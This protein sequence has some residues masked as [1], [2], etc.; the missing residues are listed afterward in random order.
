MKKKVVFYSN[1]SIAYFLLNDLSDSLRLADAIVGI[2]SEL[3]KNPKTAL[4]VDQPAEVFSNLAVF[5]LMKGGDHIPTSANF[6]VR[7]EKAIK[8]QK[9][10]AHRSL[11]PVLNNFAIFH[12]SQ[13]N[14]QETKKAMEELSSAIKREKTKKPL[15]LLNLAALLHKQGD[16]EGALKIITGLKALADSEEGTLYF[17][18]E[19]LKR[20][21]LLSSLCHAKIKKLLEFEKDMKGYR[22][23]LAPAD[24]DPLSHAKADRMFAI[25]LLKL[26]CVDRAKKILE[27]Y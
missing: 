7:A 15:Y 4:I 10:T 5:Y 11:L 9:H 20:L 14:V 1:L 13:K 26:G 23:L 19:M 24:E 17:D 27:S 2:V 3:E 21:F 25:G 18:L 8:L 16:S 22:E 12:H 6:F